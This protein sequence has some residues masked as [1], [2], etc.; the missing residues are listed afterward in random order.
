MSDLAG[1]QWNLITGAGPD[2]RVLKP[3]PHTSAY[4]FAWADIYPDT[5]L[6]Q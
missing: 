3:L 5:A 2:G 1:N 4:W 6:Y